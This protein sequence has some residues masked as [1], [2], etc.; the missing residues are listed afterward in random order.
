MTNPRAAALCAARYPRFGY[1]QR[2]STK[3]S[4]TPPPPRTSSPTGPSRP[5][6]GTGAGSSPQAKAALDA[7]LQEAVGQDICDNFLANKEAEWD[8]FIAAEGSYEG[9]DQA[10]PWELHEYLMYH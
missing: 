6:W 1:R 2:S 5:A 9:G 10:T 3:R 7:A 4:E 8:R